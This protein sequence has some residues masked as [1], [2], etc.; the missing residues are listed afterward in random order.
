MSVFPSKSTALSGGE[1]ASALE[2]AVIVPTYNEREN[3]VPLLGRLERVLA[4]LEWEIIFVDDDSPDGTAE[5]VRKLA[6]VNPRIRVLQ[7]IGRRGLASACVEGLL[8]TSAR[9]LA[10]MDADLQHDESVLPEMLKQLRSGNFDLVVASRNIAS[11][12][13]GEFTHRRAQ[14]SDAGARLSAFVCK[15]PLS[16]PMSGFFMISRASFQQ[17]VRKLSCT[18]F[19]ILVDIVASSDQKLRVAEVPYTFRAREFGE[20][21][22]DISIALEY[23][24]LL[25]D[26]FTH[27][28]IPARMAMFLLVGGTGLLVHMAV[29]SVLYLGIGIRFLFGQTI[30]T[31]VAMTWNFF[32]NNAI[33]FRDARLHGWRIIRGLLIFYATC[34]F[35]ALTNITV[36]QYVVSHSWP[37]A[38]AAI[39]GI[40]VSSVWNFVVSSLLAWRRKPL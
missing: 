34:A 9:Y 15:T 22:L 14:L 5:A 21:K 17:T 1:V 26:K 29:L 12:S 11:G 10:V 23:V 2:L 4:G 35:G 40:I 19:K 16:D 6:A 32:L 18:G 27:G 33:T 13:K 28:L 31:M 3:I 38:I 37:W 24:Y 39:T 7:R 8:A 25:I 36:A 30:A 20:S